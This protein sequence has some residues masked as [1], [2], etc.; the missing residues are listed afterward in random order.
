MAACTD[1]AVAYAK[2]RVQF[3]RTIGTFQAVKHH[4][5]DM[6]VAAELATAAVW[7][8]A[9]AAGDTADEFE[10]AAAMAAQLA[11][12][13][14]VHNAQMNIQ[15][16]GG[17]RLHLGA[18]RPPVPAA[19]PGAQR[20]AGLARRRGGRD[21]V[22]RPG[23]R[24]ATC[25]VDLPPEAEAIRAEVRA[26]AE[27]IAALPG[28]GAAQG[29]GGV[30]AAGPALAHALGPGRRRRRADRDRRGV[31][32]RRCEGARPRHHRVEHHD[33]E[34]VRHPRPGGALGLQDPHGRVRLVPAVQRARRRLGR[35]GGQDP[36]YAGRGWLEGQRPEGVDE[37]RPVLP[38]SAWRRCGP[39]PTRRSTPASPRWSS[40][41]TRPASRCGRC[42]RSRAT[43]TSTRSSSTTSSCPTTT[44]WARPNDGWTVARSTLGNER[45]S[46]GGGVGTIFPA[47]GP[48]GAAEER[49][50][51]G[52]GRR[53]ARRRHPSQGPRAEGCST[54]AGR[55]GR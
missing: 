15:V 41:C 46:I 13:P 2:E 3:G 29:A 32:G 50:R 1:A 40:T 49:G 5:A 35:G 11:F 53:G 20:R 31:A 16:H 48:A 43:P 24:P 52:A 28:R 54:S 39:T 6:L 51:P 30:G 45:V 10:L 34:P 26:E 8:A 7:D 36:G 18:R 27:R 55:S 44:W 38:T 33:G 19:G 37:R 47:D 4:C 9:R 21:R 22:R 17:H 25:R 12:G 14:A 23:A 42:A